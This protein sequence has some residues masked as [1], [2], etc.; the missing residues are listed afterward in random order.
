MIRVNGYE[1]DVLK[2]PDGTIAI[3]PHDYHYGLSIAQINNIY[4]Q[5]ESNDELWVVYLIAQHCKE[6]H[7]PMQL[8]MPYIPNARYDRTERN[9]E[10]PVL[11]YFAKVINDMDFKTVHV[12]DPHSTVSEAVFDRL[13]IV[14]AAMPVQKLLNTLEQNIGIAPLLFYPDTGA[15]KKYSGQIHKPYAYGI[16]NRDWDTG[17]ITS[18][19]VVKNGQDITNVPIVIVDDICSR[20][21]TFVLAAQK[22]KELGCGDI[23]LYISHC[24]D[25]IFDGDLLKSDLIKQIFTTNS[26]FK[27][28]HEKITVLPFEEMT[29]YG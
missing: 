28:M 4:W 26:I 29:I 14:H 10:I 13:H 8:Y 6:K 3:K 18:Y 25:T 17:K 15:V 12:L 27:S 20:G 19:Q 5:Y 9:G 1:V 21:G 7:Y 16:K 23:Y 22:L 2:F 11:K 24:E